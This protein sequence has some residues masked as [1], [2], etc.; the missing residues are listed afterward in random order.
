VKRWAVLLAL[1]AACST[2][3][4]GTVGEEIPAF[5]LVRF[6]ESLT[7]SGR[8]TVVN[9]WAS[10]CIP[11]RSET[12]LLVE[13]HHA[14]SDRINFVGVDVQDDQKSAAAFLA[15]FDVPYPNLFDPQATVRTALG[16]RGVPITYFIGSDGG[17]VATHIGVIDEQQ[18]ALQLDELLVGG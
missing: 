18:L 15:E 9:V 7:T 16:G 4:V 11:C 14:F 5:D 8:P 6:Q 17:I 3:P 2:T 10:W 1:L 13:A 12:P